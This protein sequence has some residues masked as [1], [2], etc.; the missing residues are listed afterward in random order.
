[1]SYLRPLLFGIFGMSRG[2][3]WA[4]SAGE[5]GPRGRWPRSNRLATAHMRCC[6]P[7]PDAPPAAL[8]TP[9]DDSEDLPRIARFQHGVTAAAGAPLRSAGRAAHRVCAVSGMALCK[10]R[11]A[12]PHPRPGL[13]GPGPGSSSDIRNSAWDFRRGGAAAAGCGA[14]RPPH[15]CHRW[16]S[17]LHAPLCGAPTSLRGH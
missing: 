3:R 14:R 16:L 15:S 1:V 11:C 12:R 6:I 9:A 4:G 5:M 17:A 7:R 13:V 10:R 8:L 2:C